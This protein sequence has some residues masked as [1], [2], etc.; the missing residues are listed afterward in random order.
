MSGGRGYLCTTT[1]TVALHKPVSSN[2]INRDSEIL[3]TLT[4]TL[5]VAKSSATRQRSSTE[6]FHWPEL[7][8]SDA[9]HSRLFLNRG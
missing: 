4:Q 1:D 5:A 3:K 8:S 9:L 2:D 6:G 7:I